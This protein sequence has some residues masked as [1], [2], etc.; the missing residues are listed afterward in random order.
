M[1]Q[2]AGSMVISSKYS[3]TR[4]SVHP[5]EP[6]G[7]PELAPWTMRTMSRRTCVQTSDREGEELMEG[8]RGIRG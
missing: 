5:R 2:F 8:E 3:F 4:K 7:W 6:P 1:D